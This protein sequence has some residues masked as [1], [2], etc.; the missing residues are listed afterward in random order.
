[1]HKGKYIPALS[2]NWLTPFYDALVEGPISAMQMRRGLLKIMGDLTGKN[3][4]DVGCGTGTFV[5]MMKR[6]YP[7]AAITGLDGDP[8]ILA[9]A[10]VKALKFGLSIRFTESMSFSMPFADDGFDLVVTSMMLHHLGREAKE[11]TAREMFRVLKPGGQLVGLDFA[12]SRGVVGR[13]L[14]PIT[15]HF[16]RVSE[17]LYGLLPTVFAGV[18]FVDYVELKRYV[19]GSMAL[20][21]SKKPKLGRN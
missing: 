11:S 19:L 8:D 17:N 20:F 16:E 7:D 6:A 2:L 21:G 10:R 15:R 18:G 12:E 3:V 14:R 5:T 1:M 9:A 4:L 13:G